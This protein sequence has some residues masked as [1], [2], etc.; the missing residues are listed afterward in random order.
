MDAGDLI[1]VAIVLIGLISGFL[2]KRKKNAAP[3]NNSKGNLE[4]LLQEFMGQEKEPVPSPAAPD[5]IYEPEHIAPKQA[6]IP[7][8]SQPK[9]P[10]VEN[11]EYSAKS[12]AEI[13]KEHKSSF[14]ES[15]VDDDDLSNTSFDLRQ[16]VIHSTI[17]DRTE[18]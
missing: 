12:S 18:Y 8:A 15:A 10:H 5:P 4:E 7:P 6:P 11:I 2:K 17:L 16:A 14:S 9:S 3:D 13:I 1:Y